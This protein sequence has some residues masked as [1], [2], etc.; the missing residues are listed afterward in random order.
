V[1]ATAPV[2]VA[3]VGGWT[4]TWFGSPGRV[5]HL[6]AGPGVT[7]EV[8]L[9]ED[10]DDLGAQGGRRPVTVSL[11][12]IGVEPYAI[13]PGPSGW[14][15]PTTGGHPLV[16][17]AIGAILERA[18]LPEGLRASVSVE[19][20][21]PPGASLGTSAAVVVAVLAA[22]GAA[23]GPPLLPDEIA[24]LAHHVETERVGREAGVQDQWAAALGGC[25]LLAVGPYPEV[26]H[27]PIAVPDRALSE[28][29]ERLVTVVFGPHDSSLVHAEVINAIVGCGG[30]EHD[31]ARTALRRLSA[32]A[33]D[34]AAA[35]A[36][37]AVDQW[38]EVLTASTEA[39][40]ELHEDL[41]GPPHRAAIDLARGLGARGW[42]VNG[43]GGSGGS[44]TLLAGPGGAAPVRTALA[45]ADPSWRIVDLK[46]AVA[47][48]A[49]S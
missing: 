21:V 33:G 11:P 30:V 29:R 14:A 1:I 34:A 45:A 49:V 28:L 27:E 37:G 48:V 15:A 18:A 20:A 8:H 16:E 41:V 40:G 5:C 6:A 42:K 10:R 9:G 35:L 22:V 47:G 38:G 19:S 39:Q 4:D 12:S 36:D 7:A 2:R 31:R 44:L 23:V 17:H 13:G 3:D 46:P 26:R 32:L 25:G 24:Q 43:A